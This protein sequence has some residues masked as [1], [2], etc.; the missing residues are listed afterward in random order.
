MLLQG[1]RWSDGLHQAIEAK[2]G[3]TIQN[4]TI[5]LA[6]ISYQN[7]FLQASSELFCLELLLLKNYW[8]PPTKSF[9]V[10]FNANGQ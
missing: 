9:L 6:S 5:T 3:V 7:F 4:E 10:L 2:E 8:N 1:R